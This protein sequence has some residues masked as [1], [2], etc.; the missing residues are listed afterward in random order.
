MASPGLA[1]VL[2]SDAF[3]YTNVGDELAGKDNWLA[4]E[5]Y[6]TT[7]TNYDS[8][9]EVLIG[10]GSL[11]SGTGNKLTM[12]SRDTGIQ[13][14][15]KSWTNEKTNGVVYVKFLLDVT[16]TSLCH[17]TKK[18][19]RIMRMS[20][21]DASSNHW[22]NSFFG[23]CEDDTDSTQYQLSIHAKEDAYSSGYGTSGPGE[24]GVQTIVW[25]TDI[26]NAKVELYINPS[27]T[28]A[29]YSSPT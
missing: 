28:V 25:A 12:A 11:G 27:A 20:D 17:T 22:K 8:S 10:S 23:I 7:A 24:A 9:K 5:A 1:D 13:G 18:Y 19:N 15:S 2:M 6:K 21:W 3:N 29:P 4:A 26:D 14:A 16:D